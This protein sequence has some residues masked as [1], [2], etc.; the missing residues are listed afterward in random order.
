MADWLKSKRIIDYL[1]PY[2]L[3]F[4]INGCFLLLFLISGT[5]KYETSDDF[6]MEMI[7]SGG[8]SGEPSPFVMFMNPLIGICLS[9]CYRM[10]L[11]I[12]WFFYFQL[13]W[14]YLS[15]SVITVQIGRASCRERVLAGV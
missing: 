4:L 15:M 11:G 5:M 13:L 2:R 3:A 6:L 10:L 7:V 9:F 12:N 8:Y 1:T 14:I